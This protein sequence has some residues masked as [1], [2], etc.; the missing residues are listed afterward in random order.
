VTELNPGTSRSDWDLR[1]AAS[2]TTTHVALRSLMSRIVMAVLL[3]A[4]FGAGVGVDRIGFGD[5]SNAGASSSFT[6]LPEFQTLQ[7]TWDLIH[8]NYV[9]ESAVDDQEL[10]YGAAKGMVESLGDTG[11]STFLDPEQAKAFEASTKGELIG[12]G[13]EVDFSDGSPVVIA[14]I[15]GSPADKAG[16]KARD[17]I[18]SVDGVDMKDKSQ[19]DVFTALRGDE[20]TVV[21]VT[22]ERPS[23][24]RSFTVTLKR[25]KIEV[26]PVSWTMLPGNVAFIRLSDFSLGATDGVKAAIKS[27]KDAGA[28]SMILDLRNNPGGLVFEAIGVASQFLPEGTPIYQFQERTGDARPI[29]TT[30]IGLGTDLPLAVLVDGG[31]ASS[32]EIVASGLQE[33]GRAKLFGETTYGTGT[34]LTPNEL[35]DGSVLLLG[36]GLWLTASGKQL[37]HVGVAPT[38]TVELPEGA[39]PLRPSELQ[40]VTIEQLRATNDSQLKA[41]YDEL[42]S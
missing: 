29:R 36:T 42:V 1:S 38:T 12:I 8:D 40:N 15:D 26:V 41:A 10:I 31:S 18:V 3:V 35:D 16:V 28:K 4:T 5:G 37:W 24:D 23:E 20:G 33:S 14:P 19:A 27:A 32:A 7:E 9:D 30:G 17:V 22:F 21:V 25:E 6:E 39:S 13:I 34:V 2:Q 11:H